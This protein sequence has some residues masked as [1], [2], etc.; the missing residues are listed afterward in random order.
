MF[1][2]VPRTTPRRNL[3]ASRTYT[4]LSNGSMLTKGAGWTMTE[5]TAVLHT[6]NFHILLGGFPGSSKK[7]PMDAFATERVIGAFE[8][9]C[10][11]TSKHI[12]CMCKSS[13]LP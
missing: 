13:R 4:S 9:L 8:K 2:Y 6:A 11:V 10:P 3:L 12:M 1:K 7:A 5:S